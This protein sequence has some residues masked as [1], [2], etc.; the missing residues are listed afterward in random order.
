MMM[1]VVMMLWPRGYAFLLFSRGRKIVTWTSNKNDSGSMS[2]S[3][4]LARR[5]IKDHMLKER[6]HDPGAKDEG[7]V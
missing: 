6:L 3:S 7:L 2:Q 5:L 4:H 1:M